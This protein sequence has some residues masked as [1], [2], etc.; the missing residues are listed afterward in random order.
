MKVYQ[1][2]PK[3]Q[4]IVR[5][6]VESGNVEADVNDETLSKLVYLNQNIDTAFGEAMTA[7]ELKTLMRDRANRA[8]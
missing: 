2:D 5:E 1:L 6:N 7:D 8:G 4:R 3:V